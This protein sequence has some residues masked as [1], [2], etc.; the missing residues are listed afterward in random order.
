MYNVCWNFDFPQGPYLLEAPV[1]TDK[2]E[3]VY[4]MENQT[5]TITVTLNHVNAAVIWKR[6]LGLS[7]IVAMNISLFLAKELLNKV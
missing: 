2:P 4:V 1:I 5:V 7:F 3:I 6:Y